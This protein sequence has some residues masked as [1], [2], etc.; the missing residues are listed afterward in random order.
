MEN[1]EIVRSMR[2]NPEEDELLKEEAKLAGLSVSDYMRVRVFNSSLDEPKP[3]GNHEK[4]LMQ[5]VVRMFGLIEK[6][7][8]KTLDRESRDLS[9]AQAVAVLKKWGYE[10]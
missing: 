6:M 9:E 1:K 2:L 4:H 8:F 3:E 7:A 5:I 10:E